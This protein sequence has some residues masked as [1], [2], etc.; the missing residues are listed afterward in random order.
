[1]NRI[2]FV[3]G[4]NPRKIITEEGHSL[5]RGNKTPQE[6]GNYKSVKGMKLDNKPISDEDFPAD[7]EYTEHRT[8]VIR[9]G[10]KNIEV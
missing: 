7:Y 2:I 1:M 9:W 5:D 8:D 4:K 10:S 6:E 3:N